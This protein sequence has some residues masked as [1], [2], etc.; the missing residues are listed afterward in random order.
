VRSVTAEFY[1]VTE[2]EFPDGLLCI[3]CKRV[4]EPGQPYV[5][6]FTGQDPNTGITDEELCCVYC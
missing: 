1:V 3:R 4:L 6:L 5:S 2:A